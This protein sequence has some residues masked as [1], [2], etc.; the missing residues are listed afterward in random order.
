MHTHH[1]SRKSESDLGVTTQNLL[2]FLR[3]R[4]LFQ[5]RR[6]KTQGKNGILDKIDRTQLS[7]RPRVPKTGGKHAGENTCDG[8]V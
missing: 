2:Q 3:N 1:G 8:E 7:A 4:D 5:P 6:R